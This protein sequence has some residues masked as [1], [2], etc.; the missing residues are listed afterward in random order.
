VNRA[1]LSLVILFW[2][3]PAIYAQSADSSTL[4]P[5]QD[6]QYA[7]DRLR[8]IVE[9]I[10]S[11]QLPYFP[12]DKQM[13]A[14]GFTDVYG[15]PTNVV[16]NVE[17]H[18]SIRARFLGSIEFSEPSYLKMPPDDSYC[19]KPK[20]NKSEC[21]RMWVIGTEGY[22]RQVA[23]PQRFRYEFDVTSHDL[24]FLRALKKTK[25]IDDEQ[26]V[27]GAIDSD[28][29]AFRAIKYT[30]ANTP[31]AQN[32]KPSAIPQALWDSAGRGDATSQYLIG[33]MY[34]EGNGI[35]QDYTEAYFWLDI[36]ASSNDDSKSRERLTTAR[37]AAAA[38]LTPDVLLETQKR[39]RKWF[40]NHQITTNGGAQ[41]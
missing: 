37:D 18:P 36:A 5:S 35:P 34:T 2:L 8:A 9:A 21:R 32:S 26:W 17:F 4:T 28:A 29:C 31:V 10:K 6:E 30:P 14:E 22:Q 27:D 41:P 1:I 38:H 19:N 7:I 39:A 33:T 13:E 3:I 23:H 12:L 20:M 25:Q 16:W 15:P 40:E 24:E 11:C